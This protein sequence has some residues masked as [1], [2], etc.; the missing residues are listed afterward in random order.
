MGIR[1][2]FYIARHE[3]RT[4]YTSVDKFEDA[5]FHIT[6]F[7]TLWSTLFSWGVT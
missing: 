4:I 3:F 7:K 6:K 1:V 2:V 5:L